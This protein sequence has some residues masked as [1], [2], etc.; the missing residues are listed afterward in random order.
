MTIS[1][2]PLEWRC[3][4]NSIVVAMAMP[5]QQFPSNR[6]GGSGVKM[7]LSG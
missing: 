3:L 7:I 6:K 1:C 5:S 4:G 2:H